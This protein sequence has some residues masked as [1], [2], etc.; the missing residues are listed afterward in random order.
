MI[1]FLESAAGKFQ[2]AVIL[3]DVSAVTIKLLGALEGTEIDQ[4]KLV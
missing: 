3:V 4:H 1:P 2:V